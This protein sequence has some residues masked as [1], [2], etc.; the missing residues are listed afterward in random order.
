VRMTQGSLTPVLIPE[1][2]INIAT[3]LR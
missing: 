3:H 1:V 2:T